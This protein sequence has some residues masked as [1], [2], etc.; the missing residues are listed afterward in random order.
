[1]HNERYT[2]CPATLFAND[3]IGLVITCDEE[4]SDKSMHM[5]ITKRPLWLQYEWSFIIYMEVYI[6]MDT[7]KY[8]MT[9]VWMTFYHI[10]GGI[11]LYEHNKVYH[12]CSMYD[13]SSYEEQLSILGI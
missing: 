8:I 11:Y 5:N 9:L 7:T 3:V 2:K 13:L 4:M 12:D 10:Y 6:Y 1:M